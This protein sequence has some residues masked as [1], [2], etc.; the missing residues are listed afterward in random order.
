MLDRWNADSNDPEARIRSFIYILVVNQTKIKHYGCPLGTLTSELAKLNHPAKQGANKLF[1]LFRSWLHHQ[2]TALGYQ[3]DADSL[4][5]QLLARS[6]GAATLWNAF[7]DEAFIRTEVDQMVAWLAS[8][9][10]H[11]V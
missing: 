7:Q 5:M 2:F 8:L 1:E 4:A 11:E 9:A 6:Q 10:R 3:A